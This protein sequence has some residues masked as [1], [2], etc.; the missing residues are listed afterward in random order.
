MFNNCH[1]DMFE[2]GKSSQIPKAPDVD[3]KVK[4]HP[5]KYF[6]KLENLLKDRESASIIDL[7]MGRNTITC[8]ITSE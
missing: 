6:L 2:E 8:N 4:V 7:K 5:R 3:K 1:L